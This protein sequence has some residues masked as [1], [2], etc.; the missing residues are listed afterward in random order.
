MACLAG[1]GIIQVPVVAV[2]PYMQRGELVEVLADFKAEPMPVSLLY[3]HRRHLSR[4]LL[5][6][7]E[8]LTQKVHAYMAA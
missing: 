4:R 5:A 7:M 1:L 8:W 2:R 6:F 3:P